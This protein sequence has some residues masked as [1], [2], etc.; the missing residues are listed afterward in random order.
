MCDVQAAL[1]HKATTRTGMVGSTLLVPC[2]VL[3]SLLTPG[4]TRA[5]QVG[6]PIQ[7]PCAVHTT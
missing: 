6:G 4:N 1:G 2:I 7:L 3:P 5:C